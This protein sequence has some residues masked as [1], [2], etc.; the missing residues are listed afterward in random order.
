MV[1]YMKKAR[2]PAYLLTGL[3]ALALLL[4]FS[5]SA[6]AGKFQPVRGE[7]W[8]E[9]GETSS[10]P[11]GDEDDEEGAGSPDQLSGM[12]KFRMLPDGSPDPESLK[13][14]LK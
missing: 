4:S 5:A 8:P 11:K 1:F 3:L 2:F 7:D 13:D 9:T 14:F 12:P 6:F 10:A